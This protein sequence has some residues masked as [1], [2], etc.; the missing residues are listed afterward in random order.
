[1]PDETI[2]QKK[3][4]HY[5]TI[6]NHQQEVEL[7]SYIKI[8]EKRFYGLTSLELRALAFQLAEKN[9]IAHKFNTTNGMAG[10]DWLKGFLRRHQDI[11]YRKPEATSAAR[12]MGFNRVAVGSFFKLLEDA[13][14]KYKISPQ[15]IFNVDETGVSTVPKSHSK[16]LAS[17]S[18]RQDG[19]LTSAERGK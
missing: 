9:N 18:K 15:R 13:I 19:T 8:M 17:T 14:D 6:F 11:S 1:N 2:F 12:A 16:I 5:T 7:V 10:V 3:L 4:G